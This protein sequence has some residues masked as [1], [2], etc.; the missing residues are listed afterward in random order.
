MCS[1]LAGGDRGHIF[2]HELERLGGTRSF[3]HVKKNPKVSFFGIVY[4]K[5]EVKV[6]GASVITRKTIESGSP[7]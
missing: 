5:L 6:G 7:C 3:R 4:A 1:G 2:S